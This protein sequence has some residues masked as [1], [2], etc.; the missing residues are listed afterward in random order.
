MEVIDLVSDS[1]EDDV[2]PE[3]L[4]ENGNGNGNGRGNEGKRGNGGR[5]VP[6]YQPVDTSAFGAYGRLGVY[7]IMRGLLRLRL[8]GRGR[9]KMWGIR[10][11]GCIDMTRFLG[12][13][14]FDC[15]FEDSE[16]LFS[17]EVQCLGFCIFVL[18]GMR[19]PDGAVVSTTDL[20]LYSAAT[21]ATNRNPQR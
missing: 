12:V 16:V 17:R 9:C 4:N 14:G 13:G 3:I 20:S 1:E 11:W 8:G 18:P 15:L 5:D 2:E 7:L 6:K 10:G 21:H 19:C